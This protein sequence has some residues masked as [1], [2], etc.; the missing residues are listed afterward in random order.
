MKPPLHLLVLSSFLLLLAACGN[1]VIYD[2]SLSFPGNT[3]NRFEPVDFNVNIS[4]PDDCY[5]ITLTALIDTNR[6]TDAGLPVTVKTYGP[7]GETRTLFS[8]IVL[9]N[10][11]GNWLGKPAD[12][13]QMEFSQPIREYFFF[14]DKGNHRFNIAQRTHKY[15]IQGIM[16]LN[17][18]I[19]KAKIEY[20][21]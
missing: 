2:E 20:P 4:K 13:G 14:N 17:L 18:V 16:Q 8:T 3:W 9:R 6:Y 10:V 15:D 21:K 5:N 19:E 7:Q 11:N 1:N 12:N